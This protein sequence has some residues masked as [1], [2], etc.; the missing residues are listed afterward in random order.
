MSSEPQKISAFSTFCRSFP[1]YFLTVFWTIFY[2]SSMLLPVGISMLFPRRKR[3]HFMRFLLCFF[4]WV[5]VRIMWAP[6]FRVRYEDFSGCDKKRKPGIVVVNHRAATD[7]FLVSLMWESCAQTVNGWPM[8]A[9]V[10]GWGAKL[11]GYLDITGW[12]FEMLEKN[13]AEVIS[14]NDVIVAFPEGTRSESPKMNAFH[15]GIFKIALDL[16]LPI[17]MLCIAGNEYMPDRK[18]RFRL[19]QN[20][21]IR[22]LAPIPAEEVRNCPTA[23]VLKKTVFNRMEEELAKMDELLKE[24]RS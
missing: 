20:L 3:C 21:L 22:K 14:E 11:G 10:I 23:F 4:G 24:K 5:M 2:W 7:A 6:F 18:F 9:P 12:N 19:F 13:A 1:V 8:R 16:E 17:Y 15:S